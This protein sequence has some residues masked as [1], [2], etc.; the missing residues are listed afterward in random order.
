[1]LG[2]AALFVLGMPT[3]YPTVMNVTAPR[4]FSE[5]YRP[6]GDFAGLSWVVFPASMTDEQVMDWWDDYGRIATGLSFEGYR[7]SGAG[8]SFAYRATIRRTN[9]RVLVT[10]FSGLDV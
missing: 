6:S 9:T 7:A 3:A 8:Q 5:G 4:P 10:Q 2:S 1:V